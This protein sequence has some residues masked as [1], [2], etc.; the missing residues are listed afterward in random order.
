M[1]HVV[2]AVDVLGRE[3]VRLEQ[4]DFERVLLRKSPLELVRRFVA[5]G[6]RLVHV[7]DLDGARSGVARLG[8]VER[9]A[10]AAAPAAIQFSG[11]IRSRADAEAALEAGAARVVIGTA[12]FTDGLVDYAELGEALVVALDVRDGVVAVQGWEASS[13][14]TVET[15]VERCVAA[16]VRRLLCTAIPRDGTLAGPDVP[17]VERVVRLSGLAVLAAGGVRSVV[18]LDALEEAGAEAAVV[19]RALLEGSLALETLF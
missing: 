12:A 7:V 19:G 6:A 13:G 9:L 2:P 18:D 1:L 14:L 16:G 17:L 5:A 8:L 3:A 15:A 4:G 10:A 11:G